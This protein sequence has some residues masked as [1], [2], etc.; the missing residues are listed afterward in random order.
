MP[1]HRSHTPLHDITNQHYDLVPTDNPPTPISSTKKTR[2]S[3]VWAHGKE[4]QGKHRASWRCGHCPLPI[5]KV[6]AISTTPHVIEHLRGIHGIAETEKISN[7]QTTLPMKPQINPAV[8]RK[9][10]SEWVINRRHS[11]NEIEAESFQRI[12]SYLDATAVSKLPQS[13]D[14][15]REDIIR[16]FKEACLLIAENLSTARS[17]IHLSFD[18]WTSPNYKAMLAVTGH[19][20]SA[21]YTA[22]TMLLGIREVDGP[23]EG[24]NIGKVVYDIAEGFRIADKLGYFM[25]DN[26]SNNG[27]T[28]RNVNSRIRESG[29]I[30][31]DTEERRL[32]CWGHIMNIVVKGLL[33]G[34]KMKKLVKECRPDETV[35]SYVEAQTLRWRALGAV[36]K[37]HNIVKFV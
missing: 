35:D 11:F 33:F 24:V 2:T 22:E 12:I 9:L 34:P 15:V 6:Y 5:A 20:T 3:W 32:R 21:N 36:G 27:T 26:A 17:P 8:L 30:G 14:T 19:W 1:P 13:G 18:L 16:Y 25:G 23:H 4:V 29:G 28:I 31:F 37:A 7:N 10:I